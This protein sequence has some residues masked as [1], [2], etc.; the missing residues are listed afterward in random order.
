M[1]LLKKVI[2]V[3]HKVS[4]PK[5]AKVVNLENDIVNKLVRVGTVEFDNFVKLYQTFEPKGEF[6]S[7]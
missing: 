3:C 4:S 2:S 5:K 7:Q 1:L 6:F